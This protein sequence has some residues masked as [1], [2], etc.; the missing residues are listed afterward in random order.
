MIFRRLRKIVRRMSMYA[1]GD[2][3]FRASRISSVLGLYLFHFVPR[4]LRLEP[5]ER[6]AAFLICLQRRPV[7]FGRLERAVEGEVGRHPVEE[8][9]RW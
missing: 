8:L 9:G 1:C 3:S 4:S 7:A 2:F 5:F 6:G